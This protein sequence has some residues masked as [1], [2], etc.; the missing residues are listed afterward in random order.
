VEVAKAAT[1]AAKATAQASPPRLDRA[2]E[3][4]MSVTFEKMM[5]WLRDGA[6]PSAVTRRT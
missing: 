5:N 2:I 6:A 4:V 3:F 1:V